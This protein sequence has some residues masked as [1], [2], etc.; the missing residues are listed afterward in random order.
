MSENRGKKSIS[1]CR[2]PC[3]F[4]LCFHPYLTSVAMSTA[5]WACHILSESYCKGKPIQKN[6]V[7][8]LN[9]P[10][11]QQHA[12]KKHIQTHKKYYWTCY[13]LLVTLYRWQLELSLGFVA[14]WEF[15]TVTLIA[16]PP[17]G[18]KTG[19]ISSCI[20][21]TEHFHQK[22]WYWTCILHAR[23]PGPPWNRLFWPLHSS[24]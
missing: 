6:S 7:M 5:L 17:P 3:N 14:T 9:Q 18:F 19:A 16:L 12:K 4:L 2:E 23:S 22:P 13:V 20:I 24:H 11:N 15:R 1:S 21:L 8:L 10:T